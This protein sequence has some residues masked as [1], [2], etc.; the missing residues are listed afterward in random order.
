M[1]DFLGL[2]TGG[3]TATPLRELLALGFHKSY[4]TLPRT[5]STDGKLEVKVVKAYNSFVRNEIRGDF[6]RRARSNRVPLFLGVALPG[7]VNKPSADDP[8]T[9]VVGRVSDGV[10]DFARQAMTVATGIR[11]RHEGSSLFIDGIPTS[12][13]KRE[14]INAFMGRLIN[15]ITELDGLSYAYD[16]DGTMPVL[17]QKTTE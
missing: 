2:N 13:Q 16:E 10:L 8:E 9:I 1:V 14:E 15:G 17:D 3:E 6:D 7:T 11:M 5:S 12:L 4:L